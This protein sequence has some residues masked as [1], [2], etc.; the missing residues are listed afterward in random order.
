VIEISELGR[1]FSNLNVPH[2]E[3]C[4]RKQRPKADLSRQHYLLKTSHREGEYWHETEKEGRC[5]LDDAQPLLRVSLSNKFSYLKTN[6][7]NL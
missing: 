5:N 1:Q 7:L 3:A 6:G 4:S 2:F